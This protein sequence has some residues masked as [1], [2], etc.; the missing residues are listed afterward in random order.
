[1]GDI[2]KGLHEIATQLERLVDFFEK[3]KKEKK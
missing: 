1:M 2:G 3:E